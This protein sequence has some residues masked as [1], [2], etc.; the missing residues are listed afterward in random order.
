MLL[1]SELIILLFLSIQYWS[2]VKGN[3]IKISFSCSLL[4]GVL[5][6]GGGGG[7]VLWWLWWCGL[8]G[9]WGGVVFCC[10]LVWWSRVVV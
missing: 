9:G 8:V 3:P 2:P 1:T 5:W 10:G 6:W 7:V 4:R